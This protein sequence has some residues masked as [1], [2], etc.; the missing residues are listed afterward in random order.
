MSIDYYFQ[1][2]Q[3]DLHIFHYV[4]HEGNILPFE[5]RIIAFQF[6]VTTK[7]K[8]PPRCSAEKC[9]QSSLGSLFVYDSN[10]DNLTLTRLLVIFIA[11][12]IK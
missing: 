9:T 10:E 6:A 5:S 7:L 4:L 2:S 3:D 1:D 8:F 12:I 11:V